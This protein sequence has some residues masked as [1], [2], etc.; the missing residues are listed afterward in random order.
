MSLIADDRQNRIAVP[1]ILQRAAKLLKTE[2]LEPVLT[3]L[4]TKSCLD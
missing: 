4:V 3:F 1:K 2:D